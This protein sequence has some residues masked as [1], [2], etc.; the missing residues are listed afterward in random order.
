MIRAYKQMTYRKPLWLPCI[1]VSC[2]STEERENAIKKTQ[3]KYK[4]VIEKNFEYKNSAWKIIYSFNVVNA[5][6]RYPNKAWWENLKEFED[7]LN[8]KKNNT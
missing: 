5:I 1:Y 8:W 4:W 3:L 7:K 6:P 2:D